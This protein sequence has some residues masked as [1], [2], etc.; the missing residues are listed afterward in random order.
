MSIFAHIVARAEETDNAEQRRKAEE[1]A[2]QVQQENAKVLGTLY[3]FLQRL[4]VEKRPEV[5]I[6]PRHEFSWAVKNTI[7]APYSDVQTVTLEGV[8]FAAAMIAAQS[9]VR[10]QVYAVAKCDHCGHRV[11]SKMLYSSGF[12]S[13]T[14][15]YLTC[16]WGKTEKVLASVVKETTNAWGNDIPTAGSDYAFSESIHADSCRKSAWQM[17]DY[18]SGAR[19]ILNARTEDEAQT[20]ALRRLGYTLHRGPTA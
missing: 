3:D 8:T 7:V 12:A 5:T 20:E 9:D 10:P 13:Y 17:T 4:G 18:R 19:L 6:H 16:N 11:W 15:T 14:D 1:K 2:R